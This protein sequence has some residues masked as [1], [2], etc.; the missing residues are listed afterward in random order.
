M[1]LARSKRFGGKLYNRSLGVNETKQ[2]FHVE[3]ESDVAQ[4]CLRTNR[5]G[6]S[7]LGLG[8]TPLAA[9]AVDRGH[10]GRVRLRGTR[11]LGH[12]SVEKQSN[13]IIIMLQAKHIITWVVAQQK[14]LQRC[15]INHG[16]S[17]IVA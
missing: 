15:N 9:V 1:W 5:V 14:G 6:I 10:S 4:S 13:I 7:Y 16:V 3:R 12:P 8:T 2:A 17:M 11:D